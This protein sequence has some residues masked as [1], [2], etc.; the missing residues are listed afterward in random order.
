MKSLIC[1]TVWVVGKKFL[2]PKVVD[3]KR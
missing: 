3:T 1:F 2:Y